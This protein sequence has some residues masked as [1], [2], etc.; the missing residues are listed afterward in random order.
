MNIS[1]KNTTLE[2]IH[3]KH[4]RSKTGT[5]VKRQVADQGGIE[6]IVIAMLKFRKS[7]D[8]QVQGCGALASLS[9]NCVENEKAIMR[10]GGLDAVCTAMRMHVESEEV[11]AAGC[12]ALINLSANDAE[13]P[14]SWAGAYGRVAWVS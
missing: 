14:T 8:V 5:L 9:A 7:A 1:L 12:T 13:N 2:S 4:P 11:Q 3:H 6:S 10:A